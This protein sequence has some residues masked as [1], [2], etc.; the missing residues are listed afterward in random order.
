M[1]VEGLI[2]SWRKK[3][4][5]II[6]AP[7]CGIADDKA[8]YSFVPEMIKFYLKEE[9]IIENLKTYLMSDKESFELIKDRFKE[10]VI[11]PVAESGG[12]GIVIGK[13]AS[14]RKKKR[15]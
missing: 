15:H 1:G 9:P 5:S 4:V 3:H 11:K 7:G 14:K 2:E 10:F 8:V 13:S 6:N 12:Y